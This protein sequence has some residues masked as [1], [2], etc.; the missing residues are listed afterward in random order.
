MSTD[1]Q[2]DKDVGDGFMAAAIPL[3]KEYSK[4]LNDEAA[5]TYQ[6][7]E[8]TRSPDPAQPSDHIDRFRSMLRERAFIIQSRVQKLLPAVEELDRRVSQMIQHGS[9]E[10][11]MDRVELRL[12]LADLEAAMDEAVQASDTIMQWI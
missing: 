4:K 2:N 3:L 9:L 7:L 1:L 11:E 8:I 5:L 6:L 12:R 10:S